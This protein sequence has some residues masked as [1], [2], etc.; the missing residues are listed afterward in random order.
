[1]IGG[2]A[3]GD[4][5]NQGVLVNII[6]IPNETLTEGNMHIQGQRAVLVCP[7][8]KIKEECLSWISC[9]E[10]SKK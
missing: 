4:L 8:S 1:M 2:M 5:G 6:I 9:K 7:L 3:M 10:I